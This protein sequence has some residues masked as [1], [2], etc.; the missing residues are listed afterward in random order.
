MTKARLFPYREAQIYYKKYG[1][2]P[3][4]HFDRLC[5]KYGT[6]AAVGIV[7]RNMK[8][9]LFPKWETAGAECPFG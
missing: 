5:E 3:D 7:D 6:D 1:I 8:N 9:A 4:R 2:N